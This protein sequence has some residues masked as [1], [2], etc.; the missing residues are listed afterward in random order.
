MIG[1]RLKDQ[2]TTDG[3]EFRSLT[4]SPGSDYLWDAKPGSVPAEALDW[5]DGVVSLNGASLTHLPWT[6]FYR[7]Q[8]RTSRVGATTALA[9]AIAASHNPPRVWV[10]G[11]ALGVYGDCGSVDVDETHPAGRSF[12]AQ[13]VRS[14]EAAT[15]PAQ[16]AAR[17]VLARTGIVLGKDGALKPLALATRWGLGSKVGP[18][19]QWWGWISLDDE[20]RA[21]VFALVTPELTGPVNLVGPTPA[22]SDAICHALARAMG[23]PYLFT[24]PSPLIRTVMAGADELLLSSQKAHPSALL[25]AGFTFQYDRADQVID[26]LWADTFQRSVHSRRGE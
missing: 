21:I 11:S 25:R 24:L 8:I 16:N 26:A 6:A 13:V 10:S 1:Q 5:A 18:G 9:Q 20:V 17:V 4:R 22:T 2:L 7:E 15:T 3:H 23:R 12:L 19:T 14:W